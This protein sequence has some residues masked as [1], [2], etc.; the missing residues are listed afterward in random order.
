MAMHRDTKQDYEHFLKNIKVP[1]KDL[2]SEYILGHALMSGTAEQIG[3]LVDK[4]EANDFYDMAMQV[5]Y[6]TVKEEYENGNT[7]EGLDHFGE[8]HSKYIDRFQN[9]HF[10]VNNTFYESIIQYGLVDAPTDAE[11]QS[12]LRIVQDKR[13][14]RDLIKD[15]Y[16]TVDL[17]THED[18]GVEKAYQFLANLAF[19]HETEK[20][21]EEDISKFQ[22]AE[23]MTDLLYEYNDETKRKQ[24]TINLP[25]KKFQHIVGGF[26]LEELVI[27][28]AKSGQGKSAFSLNVGI[29]TG[30]AQGIPTLYINSELSNEQMIERY[31]S[32][33]CYLDSRK[34]R[35]GKYYDA[36]AEMKVNEK[37]Y[38]AVKEAADKYY[39]S[40]LLFKRIP[41]L[42]LSNIEKAIRTDCLERKTKLVIVDYLGRMDITKFGGAKDLQEWQIMRLAANRLKTLA[43]KYHVCVIMVCQLNEEGALQGS[44]AMK[45]EADM[46]LSINRLKSSKDTYA[47]KHLVDIEPYN[48]FI[49]IEKARNVNDNS[50]ILVRYEGAMMRFCDT[51]EKIDEM[52]KAN[53]VYK[54]KYKDYTNQMLTD[55]EASNLQTVIN[56]EKNEWWNK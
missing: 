12:S 33:T 18:N 55:R 24:K 7:L 19:S 5:V 53:G 36:R 56:A 27:V 3:M 16:E 37:V 21:K 8:V 49:N 28:S 23:G 52:V 40:Q 50:C 9:I 48:T 42:Q 35:E 31:L 41:D 30:V 13:K 4:L 38:E 17:C 43:Q 29:E 47:D 25:W 6:N 45:N 26:G 14:M 46:W 11:I 34:I 22:F 51:A 39:K 44:K 32:Y 2:R 20:A 1:Y 54:D 10:D 15:L